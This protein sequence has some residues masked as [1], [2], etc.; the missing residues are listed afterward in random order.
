MLSCYDCNA[1]II[2]SLRAFA[3][4]RVVRLVACVLFKVSPCP[5]RG[6]R[7]VREGSGRVPGMG[8]GWGVE[9]GSGKGSGMGAGRRGGSTREG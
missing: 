5:Q 3:P 9:Q 2:H 6:V 8:F 7:E 4:G 1:V